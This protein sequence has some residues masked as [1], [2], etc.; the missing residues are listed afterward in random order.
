M[1]H[2]IF[3]APFFWAAIATAELVRYDLSVSES[4]RTIDGKTAKTLLINDSLPAP[5]LH[6]RVGDQAVIQLHNRLSRQSTSLHWHG[7]LLPNAQDGVPSLTTQV[8]PAGATHTYRFSLRHAGTYWYH[9]HT[10]LQEQQGLYG[11][12]VV[13]P[14]EEKTPPLREHVLVLSDFT[15][16]NPARVMRNLMRGSDGYLLRKG[17][18]PSLWDAWQKGSLADY[19]QNQKARI[20]AMDVADVAY[21]AF[22]LNGKTQSNL[23]AR[24]GELVKLRIINGSASTYFM[25]QSGLP[26][27]KIIANDGMPVEELSVK[28]I[29]IGIGETYDVL[30]RMPQSGSVEFRASAQDGSGF[31]SAIL[32]EGKILSAPKHPR[33]D[34]YRMDGMLEQALNLSDDH[35]SPYEKLRARHDTRYDAKHPRRDLTLHLTGNMER[36]RWS[37]DD[38][39]L[40][41]DAKIP[42][43]KGEVLRMTLVNDT[44]MH[45]P[46][47]L[48]GHFFRMIN[49]GGNRSPLKHTV[50]IPPMGQRTIEFLADVSGDWFF[51]CH[52]L[53]HM[54]AGMARVIAYEEHRPGNEPDLGEMSRTPWY[55]MMDGMVQ[56]NMTMGMLTLMRGDDDFVYEWEHPWEE[57]DEHEHGHGEKNDFFWRHVFDANL[58]SLAGARVSFHE[59]E[60]VAFAGLEYRL[61]YLIDTQWSIDAHGN[62]RVVLGKYQQLTDRLGVHADLEYDTEEGWQYQAGLRW[63]LNS[64]FDLTAGYHSDH[65]WGGGV[66]F[67][68]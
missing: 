24:A 62:G 33:A 56:T 14:R 32:G 35:G 46:I 66:G 68:F 65:A 44:M 41:Q 38:K 23:A 64:T 29:L 40:W 1:K 31:A 57:P 50:D 51:H 26:Q 21:D 5:T 20:P 17:S 48:H 58:A 49:E 47:H 2:I 43:R 15:R 28:K 59:Q 27:M 63:I 39:T 42:V 3:L 67:H 30:L 34:I 54:D 9:S 16:E 22:L 53:Y 25:V 10:G 18:M 12:I 8:I 19:W 4:T 6:F 13:H 52:L 7:L 37:I 61:P 55:A 45:H 60:A 36:Y 11:A